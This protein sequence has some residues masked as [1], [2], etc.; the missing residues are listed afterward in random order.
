M[1][2]LLNRI[3]N[4]LCALILCTFLLARTAP[5][6]AGELQQIQFVVREAHSHLLIRGAEVTVQDL[7]SGRKTYTLLTNRLL[8]TPTPVFDVT[9][10]R[11]ISE[12]EAF[13]Q[14]VRQVEVTL[15]QSVILIG[16]EQPPIKDIYIKVTARLISKRTNSVSPGTTVDRTK[17]EK[18][19][20]AAG[21]S[22]ASII[23]EQGGVASDS[24]GQQHV[25]GEHADISYVVDGIPLPDTLSGRQGSIIVPSTIERL[26][27]LTGGFPAEFGGQVAAILNIS[28]LP[29]TRHFHA[30]L[31]MVFGS[32]DT[33]NGDFTA[34]GPI[35][36]K[37][38]Y[39]LD[40]G[41]NRTRNYLEPQ[42]PDVQT[43]HN[44][45]AS[46]NEFFKV[47]FAPSQHDLLTL[48]MSRNP[49]SYQINNRTGLP[50]FY[51]TAGQGYGFLGIRNADGSIPEGAMANPGGFGSEKIALSSQQS[52]G[53]D[54]TAREVSEFATFSW[55][56]EIAPSTTG[57]L[58][59]TLL[60]AGQDLHNNN[61]TADLLH[62]PVD[63]SIEYSPT[64]TR[65]IH[66]VQLTGSVG[67]RRGAHEF[68]TGFLADSQSGNELYQIVPS[69]QLALNALASLAPNLAPSGSIKTDAVGNPVLDVNG[70]SIYNPNSSVS[71]VLQV[72][73]S[74]FYRAGYI[75]D[76]WKVSRK[77][78]AN[79]G[80]RADWYNQTQS[81]GGAEAVVD[82]L[83]LSPRFNFSYNLNRLSTLR[84]SYNR[85]FNTP[86]LAQGAIVGQAIQPET[87]DQYDIS[88]E[89]QVAPRQTVSLAYY[90]KQIHN[91]VDT[92]LLIPGSQIG[93][94]SAVN[95]QYGAVHGIEFSYDLT[96]GKDKENRTV[97]FDASFNYTYSIAAPNGLDNTGA[98]VDDFN[99]H[100][101]RNTLGLNVGY[102]WKSG[103]LVSFI[104]NHGS[105][106]ASSVIPPNNTRTPRTQVDFHL[107]TGGRFLNKRV[108]LGLDILNLIDDRTVINFQSAFSG[109]RFQQ[110]RMVQLSLSGKF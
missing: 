24:A 65:N 4:S 101:Q 76:T 17:I 78:T 20:G 58:A 33:T 81:V 13:G 59:F 90:V 56:R 89:H 48:T 87:L 92:G 82:T 25:R 47:R 86:P 51:T 43:A 3:P 91:Q 15:G 108:S 40:I 68:K 8:P 96:A 5:A 84:W 75:Q 63:S 30:D 107:N 95:F 36:D 49:N 106:L 57:L 10:W 97:G 54:I 99:D 73:R 64:S 12:V 21:G 102:T 103:M 50:S 88:L 26:E 41:A 93:L 71:P 22:V 53:M 62:L 94:Y 80:I 32:Y 104:V 31:G 6:K 52:A 1:V 11:A 61:P 70:N 42:Q 2:K 67:Y 109:T 39:V 44:E 85:L 34:V 7:Q 46:I 18:L 37:G 100:D 27:F 29:S 35:G 74:G 110:G 14:P 72:R 45:G 105:G 83:S 98:P 9:H 66:H 23:K 79:L 19:A 16:Q 38:S 60:H 77:L 55:K 28:T 69:S